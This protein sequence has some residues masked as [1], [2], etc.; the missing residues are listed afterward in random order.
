M[1]CLLR[2]VRQ[3]VLDGDVVDVGEEKAAVAVTERRIHLEDKLRPGELLRESLRNARAVHGKGGAIAAV[4]V[5]DVH[6]LCALR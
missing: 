1:T 2:Q 6:G 5:V 3:V 4:R